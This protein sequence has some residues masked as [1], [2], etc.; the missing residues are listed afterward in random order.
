MSKKVIMIIYHD[1]ENDLMDLRLHELQDVVEKFIIIE[2]PMGLNFK[3]RK[4]YFNDE[5]DR[6][7]F[8][9]NKIKHVIDTINYPATSGIGLMWLRR[10]SPVLMEALKEFDDD[11]FLITCDSDVLIRK[12]AFNN[13]DLSRQSSFRMNW[14]MYWYNY[15][16]PDTCFAWTVSA[17]LWIVRFAGSPG[18]MVGYAHP[19]Q[20]I[21]YIVDSGFHFSKTGGAE[22]LSE[23]IKGYPHQEFNNSAL[24]D[25]K[26]IQERID[27][28]WGWAD[29]TKGTAPGSWRWI[30]EDYNPEK[31]PQYLNEHPEIYK[32]YF[33]FTKGAKNL[34][35]KQW[36]K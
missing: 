29:L 25:I 3:P 26:G 34:G 21:Q 22:L 16:A 12:T 32:K 24:T 33:C 10:F 19:G 2:Y 5:K 31:F 15:L 35:D 9:E 17:P 20:D 30:Y 28:G 6:F 7:K 13:I 1:Y 8:F 14:Y 18:K 36:Q 27:N 4:M 11:D 23:H